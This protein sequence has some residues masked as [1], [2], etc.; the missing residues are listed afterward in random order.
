MF[1]FPYAFNQIF[2]AKLFIMGGMASQNKTIGINPQAYMNPPR[3]QIKV[4]VS[5]HVI[6]RLKL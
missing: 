6:F 3:S 5:G 1:Y 2:F 4:G